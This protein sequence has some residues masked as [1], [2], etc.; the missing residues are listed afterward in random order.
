LNSFQLLRKVAETQKM[1]G[2]GVPPVV[3]GVAPETDGDGTLLTF[4]GTKAIGR[5]PPQFGETPN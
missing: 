4:V 1:G 2:T 5:A 3:S